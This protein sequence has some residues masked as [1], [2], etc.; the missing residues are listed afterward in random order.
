MRFRLK[1][2]YNSMSLGLPS[3]LT[4]FRRK[5]IE[6]KL[7]RKWIKTKTHTYPITMDS[8]KRIKMKMMTENIKGACVCNMRKEFNL[9]HN[10]QF[11]RFRT[12]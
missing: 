10:V 11:Y 7:S 3:L 1:T 6:L 8:L 4:C 2:P 5:R 9:R 12:F